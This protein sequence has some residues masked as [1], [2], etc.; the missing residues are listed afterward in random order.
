ML[1]LICISIFL[2]IVDFM[3]YHRKNQPLIP[4]ASTPEQDENHNRKLE[5]HNLKLENRNRKLE[6]LMAKPKLD[7]FDFLDFLRSFP[8]MVLLKI[9]PEISFYPQLFSHDFFKN[10]EICYLIY[11]EQQKQSKDE[12]KAIPSHLT[13][14]ELYAD[15]F[16][17]AY[18]ML[19]M[20]TNLEEA[21]R[22]ICENQR[23]LQEQSLIIMDQRGLY[24]KDA[25]NLQIP[26][27]QMKHWI[28]AHQQVWVIQ[29][30][31]PYAPIELIYPFLFEISIDESYQVQIRS[32]LLKQTIKQR[33]VIK[34]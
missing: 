3:I 31:Q 20:I 26:Y 4:D 6:S 25:T 32:K 14:I 21:R 8:S 30:L 19:E 15:H 5:N 28:K 22:Q 10:I 9:H 23:S 17:K 12:Q 11:L 7:L 13:C 27:V 16:R 18:E 2:M 33:L 34:N 29:E 1:F 24:A